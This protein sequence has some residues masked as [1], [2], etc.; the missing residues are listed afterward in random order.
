MILVGVILFTLAIL[1]IG[2]RIIDY[3]KSRYQLCIKQ[4][5]LHNVQAPEEVIELI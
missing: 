5:L 1:S 2:T 4:I 3:T